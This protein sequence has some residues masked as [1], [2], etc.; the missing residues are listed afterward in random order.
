MPHAR[1][2]SRVRGQLGP[3]ARGKGRGGG[4]HAPSHSADQPLRLRRAVVA[5]TH[6]Q[7]LHSRAAVAYQIVANLPW[8]DTAPRA[9]SPPC[10]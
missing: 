8:L 1:E 4:V 7:C 5:L 6:E 2:G 10:T 9:S 3:R